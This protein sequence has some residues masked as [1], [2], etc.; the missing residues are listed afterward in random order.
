MPQEDSGGAASTTRHP[1]RSIAH[2]IGVLLGLSKDD[3]IVNL[4]DL[5]R[6]YYRKLDRTTPENL[7][8]VE[9]IDR[10]TEISKGI[11]ERKKSIAANRI[12]IAG[13][14]FALTNIVVAFL[15]FTFANAIR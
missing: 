15:N 1:L 3:D 2:H 4:E 7:S 9:K 11:Y 6:F 8:N 5:R 14:A 10:I 13:L 12:A